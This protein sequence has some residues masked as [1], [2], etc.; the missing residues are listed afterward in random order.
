MKKILVTGS[1]SYIG[2]VLTTYLQKRNYQVTGI[3]TGLIS[4]CILYPSYPVY[5]IY[6]DTREIKEEDIK[7]FDAVVY[8]AGISNDPFRNFDPEKIYDPVRRHTL[9]TA[10][11]CKKLGIKFIFSSSCSV[12]GKG[13]DQLMDEDSEV[14][15]Q[16]PYSL[17]KLQI[18]QD[19][20]R[21]SDQ[22]FAPIILRFAT[23]FGSSPRMR[24]DLVLNMFCAMAYTT[25]KIILN[26]DGKA[27]RPL[28]HILDVCQAIQKAI[29]YNN[30]TASPMIL[31]V[32]N[33]K[34]NYQIIELA[35][36]VKNRIKDCEIVLINQAKK[37]AVNQ[38]ITDRKIQDGVDS[39]NYKISFEK[40]EKVLKGFKTKYSVLAGVKEMLDKFSEIELSKDD[41]ENIKFYRLQTLEQLINKGLVNEELEWVKDRPTLNGRPFIETE[42]LIIR[43]FKKEDI[44]QEYVQALNDDSIINLTESRYKKWSHDEA[45]KYVEEK[46]NI[47][48]GS[49]LIGIFIK[50]TKKHI[51]N[52][53][54]HSFSQFNKRVEIGILIWDRK[55][56]GKGYATEAMQAVSDYI[57]NILKFHKICAEYY[58]LNKGSEAMFKKLKFKKEGVLR[59]HF[60]VENKFVD[61]VRVAKYNP[62]QI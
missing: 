62:R 24:F 30:R 18:E 32:G 58:I 26:S 20:S 14:F 44:T 41:F 5:T 1:E 7:G 15:P 35:K 51:G 56:W 45:V 2:S 47:P 3:D 13:I 22:S 21:L 61:A 36:L 11:I 34:S 28:V 57:F 29:E 55:Q 27:W 6:K 42:R 25:K 33:S 48:G 9:K 60:F 19:L 52:I 8:L 39:R 4:E 10:K 37:T 54:L 38:L 17:N 50:D 40:I 16:T 53:R 23:V 49:T 43:L 59:D 12:Y 31:N 46:G